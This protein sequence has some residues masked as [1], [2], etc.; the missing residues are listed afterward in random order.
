LLF[1]AVAVTPAVMSKPAPAINTYFF[2]QG[3][4]LL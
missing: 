3:K 2:M 1:R 4:L